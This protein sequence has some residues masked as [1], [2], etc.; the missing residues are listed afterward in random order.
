MTTIYEVSDPFNPIIYK[1]T[2]IAS[3][4]STVQEWTILDTEGCEHLFINN[5]LQ[6]SKN[7]EVNYHETLVHSLM[8]GCK[9]IDNVLVLGGSEGC[10][11]R[12]ILKWKVKKVTMVDWDESLITYFK[13]PGASW[14]SNS[15]DDP[16]VNVIIADAL[17]W[18]KDCNMKFDCIFID[19][20]DP[21][22]ENYDDFHNIL[23]MCKSCLSHGGG[24]SLNAG[25]I[26]SKISSHILS[27][28][29][30]LFCNKELAA[31]HCSV[32]SFKEDWA[33]LMILPKLWSMYINEI[34]LP[35]TNYYN[36]SVLISSLIWNTKYP[37]FKN[38][39]RAKKLTTAPA[40]KIL[41]CGVYYGC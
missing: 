35:Y 21:T 1:G 20:F 38:F 27:L 36:K 24:L 14:N 28:V 23:K 5:T 22:K 12:E 8:S 10:M 39:W 19:L 31:I 16:R 26:N 7:D 4:K 15:Y 40:S 34:A 32:P 30:V 41:D 29:K 25:S 37:E 3:N 13:G 2:V 9:K 18:L 11:A 6:S 33:F 17:V